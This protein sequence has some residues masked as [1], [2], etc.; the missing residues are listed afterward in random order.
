[1]EGATSSISSTSPA[2]GRGTAGTGD[3]GNKGSSSAGA[4]P[5][6]LVEKMKSAL[7]T[8]KEIEDGIGNPQESGEQSAPRSQSATPRVGSSSHI[9]GK[10]F[11][12]WPKFPLI[13]NGS[14]SA[15]GLKGPSTLA[16]AVV[17]ASGVSLGTEASRHYRS[18]H[19]FLVDRINRLQKTLDSEEADINRLVTAMQ[20]MRDS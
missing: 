12:Y 19:A 8:K 9:L 10:C 18:I 6:G 1:N 4:F 13:A 7:V 2:G 20:L 14:S 15:G 17:A 5:M 3:R 11:F 16:D